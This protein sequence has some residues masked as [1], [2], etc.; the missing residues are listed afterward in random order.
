MLNAKQ[1]AVRDSGSGRCT[2]EQ[3]QAG[4]PRKRMETQHRLLGSNVDGRE[5]QSSFSEEGHP[6]S[7]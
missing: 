5:N 4:R 1:S 2:A 6:S 3:Q 7:S